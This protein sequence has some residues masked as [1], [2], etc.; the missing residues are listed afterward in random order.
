[1]NNF[2]CAAP[3][4]GLHINIQGNVKTCCAGTPNMLSNLN[5]QS[6]EQILNGDKLKEVRAAIRQG[7]PHD[8][9]RNCINRERQGGDSERSWHN[10]VNE[11][12]DC[13]LAGLE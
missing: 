13:T 5:S 3:W 9:C 12:F 8:Y 2:Y 7:Q 10:S 6:I 11:E 4:R 1:M